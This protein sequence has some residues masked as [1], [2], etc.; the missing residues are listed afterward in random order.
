MSAPAFQIPIMC[1][2]HELLWLDHQQE[3][4]PMGLLSCVYQP[5]LE[6]TP[7]LSLADLTKVKGILL[8]TAL[9]ITRT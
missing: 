8:M 9:I 1:A 6:T 7:T 4:V 3:A 5:D 2:G